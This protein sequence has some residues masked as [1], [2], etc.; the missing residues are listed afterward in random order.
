MDDIT[1]KNRLMEIK[2]KIRFVCLLSFKYMEKLHV[3]HTSF[4]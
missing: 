1:S 4:F 2:K 3:T